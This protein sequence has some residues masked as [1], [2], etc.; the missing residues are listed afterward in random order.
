MIAFIGLVANAAASTNPSVALTPNA[1]SR[2]LPRSWEATGWCSPNQVGSAEEMSAYALQEAN[3]Q[4]HAFIGSVPNAGIKVVRIHDLLNLLTVS[5]TA[6]PLPASAYNFTLLDLLIDVV[7]RENGL[8]VGFEL[9]GNPRLSPT[10]PAGVYTSWLD[11]Q[12]LVGWRTMVSAIATRYVARYGIER[13]QH[14]RWEAW[15]EPD[16]HCNPVS[17]MKGNITCNKSGW[18]GYWGE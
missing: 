12:Q 16:H 6:H 1:P 11:P 9:M 3:W 18:L 17:K 4:N 14:W 10:S 13:V 7:V 2:S 5:S 8:H 15:N